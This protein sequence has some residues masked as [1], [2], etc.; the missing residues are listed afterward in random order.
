V[1]NA[2]TA[3]LL[4]I[5]ASFLL[6]QEFELSVVVNGTVNGKW[7]SYNNILFYEHTSTHLDAPSHFAS[8]D[9]VYYAATIPV[10][11]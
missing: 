4:N 1:V 3:T 2:S 8:F 9:G 11:R 10:E 7:L 6:D 5:C